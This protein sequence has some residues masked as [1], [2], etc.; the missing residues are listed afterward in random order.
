M[1]KLTLA[2]GLALIAAPALAEELSGD[3]AAGGD[4][5]N[6]QCVACHVVVNDAGETLAG[7]NAQVGPN[8]YQVVGNVMAHVEGFDYSDAFATLNEQ[9]E[10]WTQEAFIAYVMDPTGFLR[11]Q[12]GDRRARGRMAFQVRSA[13]QAADIYAFLASLGTAED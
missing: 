7:R 6:R 11:E 10:V 12:T 4:Q 13:D 8:L 3:A 5:F 9:G 1:K 2:A